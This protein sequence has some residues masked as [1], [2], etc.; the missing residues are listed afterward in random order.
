M[1]M[2]LRLKKNSKK[3][4]GTNKIKVVHIIPT[5]DLGGAER[6]LVD[7]VR[8]GNRDAFDFA[9]VTIVGGGPL[10]SELRAAGIPYYSLGKTTLLGLGMLVELTHLLNRLEPDIVHTHL[11]GAHLWGQVA[12]MLNRVPIM[13]A[14]EQNTDVDLGELKTRVKQMLSYTADTVIA[15]SDAIRTFLINQGHISENKIVVIRN[16]IETHRYLNLPAPKFEGSLKL[17][18]IGRLWPQKGHDIL[19]EALS[20]MHTIPWQLT[21]IGTGNLLDSL[22]DRVTLLHLNDRVQFIGAQLD[23]AEAIAEHDVVVMPSR[24]E[25]IGLVVMEGMAAGRCVIAS[26]VGGIPELIDHGKTGL[27]VQPE[28][29]AALAEAI[30]WVWEHQDI[31]QQIGAQAREYARTH[32]D[33]KEMVTQYERVYAHLINQ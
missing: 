27:L 32:C 13:V 17:L 9:V 11:F 3:N 22:V 8:Y 19:I 25:G 12:S 4:L 14:S 6:I 20:G 5:L 16:A 28:N 1:T 24:W 29:P 10:E 26:N 31:A 15:A 23:V 18:V 33:I 2:N 30:K 21:I 7:L